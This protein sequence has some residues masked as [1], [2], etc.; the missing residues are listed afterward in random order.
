[1][2]IATLDSGSRASEDNQILIPVKPKA[3]ETWTSGD[4][5]TKDGDGFYL[6][7]T[8]GDTW[9]ATAFDSL[10]T[11]PAASGDV[12]VLA[13]FS[14]QSLFYYGVGTGTITQAMQGKTCDV[15][16]ARTLDVTA[17]ADDCVLIVRPDVAN[18]A[19]WVQRLNVSLAAANA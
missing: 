12:E 7:A 4:M 14:L 8:A 11:A 6:K 17:S 15:A 13:D 18:N 5:L 10:L 1:M 2:T 19:A 3:G 16:G 9:H